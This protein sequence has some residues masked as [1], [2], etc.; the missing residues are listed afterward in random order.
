MKIGKKALAIVTGLLVTAGAALT[1]AHVV[2]YNVDHLKVYCPLNDILGVEHQIGKINNE[3][4]DQGIRAYI[5]EKGNGILTIY[6]D[7]KTETNSRGKEVYYCPTNFTYSSGG[8]GTKNILTDP[9]KNTIYITQGDVMYPEGT[10]PGDKVDKKDLGIW[11][12]EIIGTIDVPE[13]T[14]L[15]K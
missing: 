15:F 9:T 11:D 13:K 4:A 5:S 12:P 7:V 14:G 1:G 10:Q 2:D 6:S 3:Y 8:K